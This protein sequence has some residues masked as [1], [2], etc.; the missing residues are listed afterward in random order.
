M[1]AQV[2]KKKTSSGAHGKMFKYIW[3]RVFVCS[4][5]YSLDYPLVL[6]FEAWLCFDPSQLCWFLL[7]L[8]LYISIVNTVFR[9]LDPKSSQGQLLRAHAQQQQHV[10][11][12]IE[13]ALHPPELQRQRWVTKFRQLTWISMSTGLL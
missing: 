12:S 7:V 4:L 8:G 9:H 6:L 11:S 5:D 13:A 3:S 1:V 10:S 2:L